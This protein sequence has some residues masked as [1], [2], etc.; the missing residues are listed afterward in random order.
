MI[1]KPRHQF[2]LA[3]DGSIGALING[4]LHIFSL[5]VEEMRDTANRLIAA[6]AARE[7]DSKSLAQELTIVEPEG[8]A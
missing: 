4:E 6:A 7:A 8:N 5:T 3:D 1:D 2:L